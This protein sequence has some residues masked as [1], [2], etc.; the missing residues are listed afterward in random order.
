MDFTSQNEEKQYK[1]WL[2]ESPFNTVSH[3][4]FKHTIPSEEDLLGIFRHDKELIKGKKFI[5]FHEFYAD[6]FMRF[7]PQ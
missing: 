7:L 6:T 5:P 4:A 2:K 1:K 3:A